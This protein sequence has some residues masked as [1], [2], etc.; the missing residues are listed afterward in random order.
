[1]GRT[2]TVEERLVAR[3]FDSCGRE[4]AAAAVPG[5]PDSAEPLPTRCV[6]GWPL[7]RISAPL[8][9]RKTGPRPAASFRLRPVSAEARAPWASSLEG[10]ANDATEIRRVQRE[11]TSSSD[12]GAEPR[13]AQR[14]R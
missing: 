14:R 6:V 10:R 5:D 3:T 2:F 11:R 4:E 7:C 13:D 9:T 8:S 1:M 12:C